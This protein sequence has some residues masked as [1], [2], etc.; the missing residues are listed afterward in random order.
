MNT[1]TFYGTKSRPFRAVALQETTNF[2][3]S[4]SNAASAT[5]TILPPK[6]GDQDIPC[7]EE[8]FEYGQEDQ[9]FEPAGEMEVVACSIF[10]DDEKEFHQTG[11]RRDS[12]RW[13]KQETFAKTI[14]S[15]EM[16][17]NIEEKCPEYLTKSCYEIW[18]LFFTDELFHYILE[19]TKLYAK[20]NKNDPGFE[21]S[22]DELKK[23]IGI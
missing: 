11:N 14:F 16:F 4:C 22:L 18:K 8:D 19:Q 12:S 10:D 9:L 2:V 6:C 5:V 20:Q 17:S 1:G 23:F 3:E 15:E 7:D 13:K 21:L